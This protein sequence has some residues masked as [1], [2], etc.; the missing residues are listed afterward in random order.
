VITEQEKQIIM[1]TNQP[2]QSGVTPTAATPSELGSQ[3]GF[4]NITPSISNVCPPILERL[5]K[6]VVVH[7]KVIPTQR[8]E[9]QP[10]IHRD[11]EQVE[12]H[13]VM[14]PLRERDIAPTEV[15]R[16]QLPATYFE[17]RAP[18]T[19]FQT[20]YRDASTRIHPETITAP[21]Q[22]EQFER[23]PIIEETIHRK[24][25]EEVQP[26]L[27]KETVRPTIVEATK[28]IYEHVYESPQ[29]REEVRPMV[30][31]GTKILGAPQEMQQMQQL[32]QVLEPQEGNLMYE[33]IKVTNI[34]ILS[35]GEQGLGQQGQQGLGQQG[36][37]QQGLGQ[38]GFAQ[39]G[40]G[41]QGLGQQGLG[42]QGF[43]QQGLGQQG[44]GQQGFAQ[45]G[46]GQQGLPSL[47]QG[48]GQQ[49]FGQQGQEFKQVPVQNLQKGQTTASTTPV[50]KV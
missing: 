17:S 6:P 3:S 10:V 22:T 48:S 12:F 41:Q 7:E 33:K 45:Q 47:A 43:A 50:N 24:I 36:F 14:Q 38:Q 30:D 11:R 28:P 46:L 32:P 29:L 23:A 20:Q 16:T 19:Q 2:Y 13:K 18:D 40:L 21:L 27:Y 26:V 4:Q 35:Q 42:Q 5:E 9:V 8:T 39:Q 44:L 37:A 49:G 34:E 31:L 15:Q 1:Q 25:I